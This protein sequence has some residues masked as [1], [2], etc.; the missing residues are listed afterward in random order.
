[1]VRFLRDLEL[2]LDLPDL[3]LLL[4]LDPIDAVSSELDVNEDTGGRCW[5]IA[6][7]W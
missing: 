3:V 5:C 6:D 7:P 4:L 2:P 1:M